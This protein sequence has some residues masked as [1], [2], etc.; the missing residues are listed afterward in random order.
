MTALVVTASGDTCLI[1]QSPNNSNGNDAGL[2]VGGNISAFRCRTLLWFDLSGLDP[3]TIINSAVLSLW[4]GGATGAHT[5][6]VALIPL[7]DVGWI[8]GGSNMPAA[9]GD[10]CWNWKA[11]DTVAWSGGAGCYG[12]LLLGTVVRP[13]VQYAE[14]TLALDIAVV[15][16]W[17]GPAGVNP[18]LVVA[19]YSGSSNVGSYISRQSPNLQPTLILDVTYPPTIPDVP[20]SASD[21]ILEYS[22]DNL[23]WVDISGQANELVSPAGRIVGGGHVFDRDTQ[24]V[25]IGKREPIDITIRI[26]YQEEDSLP[27][28]VL[29]AKYLAQE[30]VWFRWSSLLYGMVGVGR[31]TT[32]PDCIIAHFGHPVGEASSAEPIAL[33][34]RFRAESLTESLVV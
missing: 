8:E 11:Y 34:I 18:G 6:S 13:G 27:F 1:Q 23:V 4:T 24:P 3:T 25:T 5:Q 29:R 28:D 32:D 22:L 9:A 31:Y 12:A 10:P 21:F 14:V 16:A 33:E 2:L 17:V 19:W 26:L 30:R 7:A 20:V 15:Q